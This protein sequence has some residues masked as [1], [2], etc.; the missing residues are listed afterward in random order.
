MAE[1][2]CNATT[3]YNDFDKLISCVKPGGTLVLWV[4]ALEGNS[5][6]RFFVEP[7]RKWFTRRLPLQFVLGVSYML[8]SIFQIISQWIYK[9]MNKVNIT[10]LPMN[11]YIIYRTNFNYKMNTEMIFTNCWL[12]PPIEEIEFV[13]TCSS[14]R[15]SSEPNPSPDYKI[16]LSIKESEYSDL[17]TLSAATVFNI[18]C[19]LK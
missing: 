2:I 7:F 6:V 1:S 19:H 10:W 13:L 9:R 16:K 5:F 15:I 18:N 17:Y 14:P 3:Y 12:L 11:G 8:G 4:Y